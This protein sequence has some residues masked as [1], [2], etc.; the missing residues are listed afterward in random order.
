[1]LATLCEGDERQLIPISA[2]VLYDRYDGARISLR[3]DAAGSI[4]GL[5]WETVRVVGQKLCRE[6]TIEAVKQR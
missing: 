3:R 1:M 6:G 5:S 4:S 2:D